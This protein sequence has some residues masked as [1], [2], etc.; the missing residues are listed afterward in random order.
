V[1]P[2]CVTVA[3]VAGLVLARTRRRTRRT[4]PTQWW[5]RTTTASTVTSSEN[6]R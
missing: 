5:L 4:D 1:C 6:P 3:A 2:L